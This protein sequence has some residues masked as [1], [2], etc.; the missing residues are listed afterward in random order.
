MLPF[1]D[2]CSTCRELEE[3]DPHAL[4]SGFPLSEAELGLELAWPE[5]EARDDG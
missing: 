3:A 4:A 1:G 5:G 2:V